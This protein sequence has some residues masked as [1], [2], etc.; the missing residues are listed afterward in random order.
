M[1]TFAQHRTSTEHCSLNPYQST[2]T[3]A[4][5]QKGLKNMVI[6]VSEYPNNAK[7]IVNGLPIS[8][9]CW[10]L[11]QGIRICVID[12]TTNKSIVEDA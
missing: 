5:R 11:P 10:E 3:S 2:G 8:G 7:K 12:Q 4:L 9:V 1:C 6:V